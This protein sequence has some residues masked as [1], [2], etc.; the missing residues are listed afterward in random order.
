MRRNLVAIALLTVILVA[1]LAVGYFALGGGQATSSST[2]ITTATSSTQIISS[3]ESISSTQTT[4]STAPTTVT[5]TTT[6]TQEVPIVIVNVTI[7]RGASS[8]Q[9][10]AGYSPYDLTVLIG[11]NNTV[12]WTNDDTA[13]HT[14]SSTGG[15]FNSGNLN[16]GMSYTFTFTVPGTYTYSCAYHGWMHGTIVVKPKP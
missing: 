13:A 1:A 2:S 16:P 15:A 12:T 14:V 8:N 7:S 3:T 10:S 6:S 5:T 9:S 11:V 4:T